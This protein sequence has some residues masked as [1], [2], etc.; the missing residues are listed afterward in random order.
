MTEQL[1]LQAET[2]PLT[3]DEISY[4]DAVAELDRILDD[5]DRDDV[6]ID[7]L[8]DKLRR[9]NLLIATLQARI[10]RTREEVEVILDSNAPDQTG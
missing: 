6:D 2:E 1:N 8:G 4:R 9:A 3:V 10:E 5:L 7:V